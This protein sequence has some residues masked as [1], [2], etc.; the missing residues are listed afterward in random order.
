[1]SEIKLPKTDNKK[2]IAVEVDLDLLTEVHKQAKHL[3]VTNR[4]IIEYGMRMWLENIKT[5][6]RRKSG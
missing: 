1:M 5:N 4:S 6:N 3:K 2:M